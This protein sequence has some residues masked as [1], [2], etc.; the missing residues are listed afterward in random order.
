MGYVSRLAGNMHIFPPELTVAG[1]SLLYDYDPDLVRELL[2]RLVP[3]NMLLVVMGRE[4]KGLTNKVKRRGR[5]V[6]SGRA[7]GEVL[8][9][10]SATFFVKAA[11]A[12][13]P[14]LSLERSNVRCNSSGGAAMGT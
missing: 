14:L 1:P 13:V 4:F 6:G 5:R 3:S 10:I 9:R 8:A 2:G 12:D 7:G 11:V